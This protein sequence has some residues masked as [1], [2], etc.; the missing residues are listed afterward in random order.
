MTPITSTD[1]MYL[2]SFIF[3]RGTKLK[4]CFHLPDSSRLLS[5]SMISLMRELRSKRIWKS[6]YMLVYYLLTILIYPLENEYILSSYS[7]SSKWSAALLK[8][9][10]SIW[11]PCSSI[12]SA[13]KIVPWFLVFFHVL[14]A[15]FLL[16]LAFMHQSYW[17]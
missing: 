5:S 3:P 15:C 12:S 16:I 17:N 14:L 13:F 8:K 2:A 6:F 7:I 9:V 10:I 11:E 4:V 1:L